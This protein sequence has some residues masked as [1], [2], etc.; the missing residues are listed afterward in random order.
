M[1][2]AIPASRHAGSP[3]ALGDPI[4]VGL[5]GCRRRHGRVPW[6]GHQAQRCVGLAALAQGLALAGLLLVPAA[7]FTAVIGAMSPNYW[8]ATPQALI[9]FS[10][11]DQLLT[12]LAIT[13]GYGVAA[14]IGALFWPPTWF[15]SVPMLLLVGAGAVAVIWLIGH[16]LAIIDPLR[17]GEMIREWGEDQDNAYVAFNDLCRLVRGM[18]ERERRDV[19]KTTVGHMRTLWER[20]GAEVALNGEFALRIL[21][22][23]DNKWNQPDMRAVTDA[24]R[25]AMQLT[26]AS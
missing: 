5:S 15:L 16:S 6:T 4:G 22:E 21:G 9:R 12:I 18:K 8:K 7:I 23:I 17:L 19:A 3:P 2:R 13:L 20:H 1:A 24:C 25:R 26:A 10:P 14:S 11:H